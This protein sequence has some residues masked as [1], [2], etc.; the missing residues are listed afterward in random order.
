MRLL[1]W[2]WCCIY[3]MAVQAMPIPA[4]MTSLLPDQ[5]LEYR[6]MPASATLSDVLKTSD[7]QALPNG[8]NLG[9]TDAVHWYRLALEN[10]A[11]HEYDLLLE[12]AYSL[13]DHVEFYHVGP[14]QVL[15]KITVG[16]KQAF[17]QRPILQR[18]FL[19]P[20]QLAPQSQHVIYLRVQTSGA[21]Q[22]PIKLWSRNAYLYHA[23]QDAMLRSVF[24]GIQTALVL[25]ICF[26]YLLLR[27]RLFLYYTLCMGSFVLL[28][29]ALQ[30]VAFQ[31][32]YPDSPSLHEQIIL[33]G[34][35]LTL[36]FASLYAREFLV[37][38]KDNRFWRLLFSAQHAMLIAAAL[39]SFVLPYGLSTRISVFMSIP[40]CLLMLASG[41]F[42]WYRGEQTAKMFSAAWFCLMAGIIWFV[43][44][45]V[46][47]VPSSPLSEYSILIGACF[48][49]L[50]LSFAMA[51]RVRNETRMKLKALR[52]QAIAQQ[53]Q[54][55]TETK[56]VHVLSHH[57]LTGL[58]NKQ[59]FEQALAQLSPSTLQERCAVALCHITNFDDVNKTLG[60]RNADTLIK[61]AVA[62]LNQ[63]LSRT[64]TVRP[65]DT[66]QGHYLAHIEGV[67]FAFL[68]YGSDELD[69]RRKLCACHHAFSRPLEQFGLSL[70]LNM[71]I[72]C[73][74][75]HIGQTPTDSATL[76]RQASIAFDR[77]SLQHPIAFF[78][79]ADIEAEYSTDRLTLMTALRTAIEKEELTL[80]FQP[81]INIQ[82]HRLAGF[83]AL[84][85][86]H[87]PERGNIAPDMFIPMA[88]RAGLM[89]ELTQLVLCK[90]IAF[91]RQLQTLAPDCTVSVNISAMNLLQEDFVE[92]VQRL[93]PPG[94]PWT[95]QVVLE[96]TETAAM[97][98]PDNALAVLNAL[99]AS[100]IN[101]SIDDFGTGHSSLTYIRRLPVSEIKIDRS[102][103]VNMPHNVDDQVIVQTLIQMC[104]TLGYHIVAEGVET[105]AICQQLRQMGCDTI[106]G[107]YFS[108]PLPENQALS[109]ASAWSPTPQSEPHPATA[110][111][112]SNPPRFDKPLPG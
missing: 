61:L 93:L 75:S 99:H 54:L 28:A 66:T 64:D 38:T 77:T 82:Q 56:L 3:C 50:L 14:S 87:H 101:M 41:V 48:Q 104:H 37:L 49:A 25:F 46:G 71:K 95:S 89:P 45:K 68:V 111:P 42:C 17:H 44:N 110:S 19:F 63:Y 90:A 88:E 62:R 53:Q 67:T 72:G 108:R 2:L 27:E 30:G 70:A 69:I 103:I 31:W 40:V 43:L 80:C 1:H 86:W 112:D 24:Y 73:S 26:I 94:Q 15:H 20:V 76:L 65:L 36:Y 79:A 97:E 98:D 107:Y 13:L 29:M 6:V 16:D 8:A 18:N 12:V 33:T 106:Q 22:V 102:F 5:S 84:L 34:V 60:H 35:P 78:T 74:L 23:E 100:G 58:P 11:A 85:R 10:P 109:F 9:Y 83:E 47:I 32:L 81:Q 7:W 21:Q 92:Q 52:Q 4:H 105:E 57:S 39:F 96:V 91:C 59:V 55:D 51:Q